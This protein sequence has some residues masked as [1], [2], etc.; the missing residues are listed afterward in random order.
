VNQAYATYVL[1]PRCRLDEAVSV[2]R[3]TISLDPYLPNPQASLTFLLGFARK[4]DEA[5]QQHSETIAT[6]PNYYYSHGVMSL[7]YFMNERFPEA[8]A[9]AIKLYEA[10]HGIPQVVGTLAV[11]HAANGNTD[12]AKELLRQLLE[13]KRDRY[14]RATDLASICCALGDRKQALAWLNA[15]LEEKSMHLYFMPLD[16][17]LRRLHSD[18]DFRTVLDR[19]GLRLPPI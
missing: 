15:A 17:R 13:A 8:L 16:P 19:I 12:R 10:A 9:E 14:I 4:L 5:E 6:N 18:P 1:A 3:R 11:M 2:L 7:A